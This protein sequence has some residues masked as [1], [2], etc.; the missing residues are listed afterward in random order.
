MRW[1]VPR[2]ERIVSPLHPVSESLTTGV[3]LKNGKTAIVGGGLVTPPTTD[4]AI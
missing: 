4:M 1:D 3:R 2:P